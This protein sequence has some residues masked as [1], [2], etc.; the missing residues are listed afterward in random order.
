MQAAVKHLRPLP[1]ALEEVETLFHEHHDRVFRTAYRITGSVVDAEDVLQTIFLRLVKRKRK[2]DL[3]PGPESYLHRAAINASL[4]L[5]RSRSRS[6]SV[7]F[8]EVAA[9]TIA[10]SGPSPEAE[11][12]NRELRRAIRQS[13]ARL[14]DRTAEIVVLKYF[15]GYGNR[16]IAELLGTSQMVVAVYLHRARARLRKEIGKFLEEYH[17]TE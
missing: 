12:A 3:S 11:H 17:E 4:D 10:S 6:S 16:E 1:D 9:A 7:S 15:E 8:E 2:I 13:V 14:S 5:M